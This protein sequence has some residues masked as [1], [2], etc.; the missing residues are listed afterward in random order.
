[1]DTVLSIMV[2]ATIALV[3]GAFVLWRRG[4][5]KKQVGLM[6]VLAV[7]IAVNVAIWTVPD[8]SGEAPIEKTGA[9]AE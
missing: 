6:L 4:G 3:I 5:A 1:M 2:L 8:K 7:V 9:L